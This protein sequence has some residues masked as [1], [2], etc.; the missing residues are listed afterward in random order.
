MI[1]KKSQT[2][3]SQIEGLNLLSTAIKTPPPRT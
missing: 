3:F 2:T 1:G